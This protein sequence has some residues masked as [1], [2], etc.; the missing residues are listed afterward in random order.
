MAEEFEKLLEHYLTGSLEKYYSD[1]DYIDKHEARK[2]RVEFYE[3]QY[4]G[5]DDFVEYYLKEFLCFKEGNVKEL[6]H[7]ALKKLTDGRL[8]GIDN[9]FAFY[10]QEYIRNYYLI[11]VI[12]HNG[13]FGTYLNPK[14]L[15]EYMK[16]GDAREIIDKIGRTVYHDMR[17][18]SDAFRNLQAAIKIFEIHA[19]LY[20]NM[21]KLI[22]AT[23]TERKVKQLKGEKNNNDKH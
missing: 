7:A 4:I 1:F 6:T 14:L 16:A 15:D 9:D 2:K 8:V 3:N 21:S 18:V 10:N 22:T 5:I 23:N 19:E 13:D 20:E 11:V 12:D 17:V